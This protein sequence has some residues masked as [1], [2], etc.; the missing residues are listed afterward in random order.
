MATKDCPQC[1]TEAPVEDR[2]C[3]VC[4]YKFTVVYAEGEAQ[5]QASAEIAKFESPRPTGM[6]P[7]AVGWTCLGFSVLLL[8]LS[9][10]SGPESYALR[11]GMMDEVAAAYARQFLMQVS[12]GA[13][14]SLFL[15][16]WSVGYIVR[17]LSYLPG[18]DT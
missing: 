15:V 17:A 9:L 14:F 3:A 13:L 6:M 8:L 18:K 12:A 4:N 10:G 1:G 16:F 5:A 2:Q 11:L 7:M